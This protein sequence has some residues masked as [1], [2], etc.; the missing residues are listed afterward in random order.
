MSPVSP[1]F[2]TEATEA[3]VINQLVMHCLWPN[4]TFGPFKIT[5]QK[6]SHDLNKELVQYSDS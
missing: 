5:Y 4:R 3:T 6:W 1:V 2:Y